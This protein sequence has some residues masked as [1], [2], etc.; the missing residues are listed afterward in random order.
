MYNILIGC[1]HAYYE[2][3]GVPLLKSVKHYAPWVNLHAH[4]VNTDSYTRLA[5]V[6]YTTET[7]AFYSDESRIAYLQAVRFLKA[8]ELFPGVEDHIITVDADSICTQSFTPAELDSIKHTPTILKHQ[9]A[10]HWLAGFVSYGASR[11]KKDIYD[12]ILSEPIENWVYGRDQAC[13]AEL[14]NDIQYQECGDRWMKVGKPHKDAIFLTL[15]GNQKNTDKYLQH[16]N[17]IKER[18]C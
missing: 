9:K 8:Y 13:M 4:I 5:D 16:Y 17:K 11:F 15:K 3:W 10:G 18:V 12:L 14:S 1:D 2:Q 6:N 7:R